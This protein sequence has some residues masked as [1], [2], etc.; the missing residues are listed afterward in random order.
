M[1][2]ARFW[3]GGYTSDAAAKTYTD[4]LFRAWVLLT[5]SAAECN[6]TAVRF[7]V[8]DVGR[9]YLQ[10]V[11]CPAAYARLGSAWHGNYSTS[12][13]K[14]AAIT[15]AGAGLDHAIM[16]IDELLSS[17]PGFL[18]GRWIRDA[19]QLGTTPAGQAQLAYNAKLQVTDWASYPPGEPW[20]HKQDQPGNPANW[21]IFSGINDY[22]IKQWGGLMSDYQAVRFRMYV[23]QAIADAKAGKS[24][25]C[26]S[27]FVAAFRAR[28]QKWMHEPWNKTRLPA[29][30]TGDTIAIARR[31]QAQVLQSFGVVNT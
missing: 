21:T 20:S 3:R 12:A 22:A 14:A 8:A 6:T 25:V 23:A 1:E 16:D 13:A 18:F 28:Q 2:P 10:S 17:V 27:C 7:D 9:E 29:T 24:T 31:L 4:A 19:M 30:T 26:H 11:T 15:T 5:D